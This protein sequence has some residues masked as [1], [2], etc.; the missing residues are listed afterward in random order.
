MNKTRKINRSPKIHGKI[1]DK[2][3]EKENF[4]LS[5][6]DDLKDTECDEYKKINEKL[7]VIIE[8]DSY[9]YKINNGYVKYDNIKMKD[10]LKKL[11]KL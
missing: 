4:C 11:N 9:I 5:Q 3:R 1:I 7:D 10:I 8:I 2:I 6:L